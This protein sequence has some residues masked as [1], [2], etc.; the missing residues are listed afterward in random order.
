MQAGA[1]RAERVPSLVDELGLLDG[2]CVLVTVS[3]VSHEQIRVFFV[4][5]W[6]F[7]A[8]S[9]ILKKKHSHGNATTFP[10]TAAGLRV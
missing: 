7:R 10:R 9:D 5:V 2:Q 4:I 1:A 6:I 3:G 8:I